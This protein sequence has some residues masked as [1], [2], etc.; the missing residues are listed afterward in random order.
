M[1]VSLLYERFKLET[2]WDDSRVISATDLS[3]GNKVAIKRWNIIDQNATNEISVISAIKSVHVP[4]FICS[5]VEDEYRYMVSKWI[6]GITL[7]QY[8]EEK[9]VLSDKEA[10]DIC[11]KI[12]EAL[13]CLHNFTSG[14]LI[15]LDLKPSNIIVTKQKNIRIVDFEGTRPIFKGFMSKSGSGNT[16]LLGSELYTAPEVFR[17][18]YFKCS[19]V[20]SLGIIMLYMVT[21]QEII[22]DPEKISNAS[23]KT[24]IKKCT[25]ID[26]KNRCANLEEATQILDMKTSTKSRNIFEQTNN[27]IIIQQKNNISYYK[28]L[29]IYVDGNTAFACELAYE[30][31]HLLGLNTVVFE[32]SSGNGGRLL[33]FFQNEKKKQSMLCEDRIFCNYNDKKFFMMSDKDDWQNNGLITKVDDTKN[34]FF[35][36]YN[37][38]EELGI[39]SKDEIKDFYN[40]AYSS[41]DITIIAGGIHQEENEKMNMM[42]YSDYVIAA[43]QSSIDEIEAYVEYYKQLEKKGSILTKNIRYVAWDYHPGY[44]LPYQ[45]IALI[46]EK[47][48]YL[49]TISHSELRMINQNYNNDNFCKINLRMFDDQYLNILNGLSA[50]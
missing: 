30:A 40:W 19:D 49:G 31:A 47:D 50:K 26:Y 14:P 10:I 5:F 17:G 18:Q 1:E 21:G 8:V 24:F 23:I 29:I 7:E 13:L 2:N 15:F 33:K 38:F 16:V 39:K 44:S 28:K 36:P 32:S 22:N 9:K 3:S 42:L 35:S 4:E 12:S 6:D 48:K 45:G 20:Y 46:V 41:F 25:S 43:P 11:Q 37:V 27:E 34:L